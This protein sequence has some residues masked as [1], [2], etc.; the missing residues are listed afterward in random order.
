MKAL[1]TPRLLTNFQ[2]FDLYEI[3]LADFW[4]PSPWVFLWKIL[5][6]SFFICLK[7]VTFVSWDLE[8]FRCQHTFSANI[9]ATNFP[10]SDPVMIY[11]ETSIKK[12]DSNV[13]KMQNISLICY[14]PPYFSKFF[15][16]FQAS[17]LSK[18]Y[19]ETSSVQN[20]GVVFENDLKL[21]NSTRE[22][23][24]HSLWTNFLETD[25][26][27]AKTTPRAPCSGT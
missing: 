27:I 15:I 23:I 16:R 3:L 10:S 21:L 8:K 6:F 26:Q 2:L 22:C 12:L 9:Q 1:N 25:L 17:D 19:Y 13:E 14:C 4:K 7:K 20:I 18:I 24:L 5:D 11:Q